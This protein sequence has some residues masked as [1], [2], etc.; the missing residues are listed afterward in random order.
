MIITVGMHS[1]QQVI[2]R[3][4]DLDMPPLPTNVAIVPTLRDLPKY[5]RTH[6]HYL[7]FDTPYRLIR[8]ENAYPLDFYVM[9]HAK[10]VAFRAKHPVWNMLRTFKVARPIIP[11]MSQ[12]YSS[13]DIVAQIIKKQRANDVIDKINRLKD[14]L[15]TARMDKVVSTFARH[16]AQKNSYDEL[17]KVFDSACNGADSECQAIAKE[18]LKWTVSPAADRLIRAMKEA[19]GIKWRNSYEAVARQNDVRPFE[20]GFFLVALERSEK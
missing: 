13:E 3:I 5:S 18:I 6:D 2:D 14:H 8:I 17:K 20:L 11:V 1:I 9:W 19:R 15:T 10:P 4:H 12:S 7:I 16:I